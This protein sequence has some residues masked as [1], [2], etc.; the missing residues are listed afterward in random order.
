VQYGDL[1]GQPALDASPSEDASS[2]TDAAASRPDRASGDGVSDDG[3]S[4][5]SVTMAAGGTATA[6]VDAPATGAAIAPVTQAWPELVRTLKQER[7]RVGTFLEEAEPVERSGDTVVV[8]VPDALHRD[9]LRDV[10]PLLVER[11]TALVDASIDRLRF[12]IR[13]PDDTE[14]NT[15]PDTLPTSPRERLDSLRDSYEA[16]DVLFNQFG[17]EMAW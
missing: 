6:Q 7:I 14:D 12:E 8:A 10:Q 5:G 17:A 15:A 16:L 11:L 9:Q 2:R 1:F 3:A 4:D 13:A